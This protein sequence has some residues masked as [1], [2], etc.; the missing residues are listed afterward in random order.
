[1]AKT[2]KLV[3]LEVEVE[4]ADLVVDL[5][6]PSNK[7]LTR[8]QRNAIIENDLALQGATIVNSSRP[9][10]NVAGALLLVFESHEQ[11]TDPEQS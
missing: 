9:Q 3:R 1:M 4:T 7:T 2:R 5:L 11:L 6:K 10:A 8:I